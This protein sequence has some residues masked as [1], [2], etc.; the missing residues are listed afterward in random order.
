MDKYMT[1]C[2]NVI[3][4][5][6]VWYATFV[7]IKTNEDIQARCVVNSTWICPRSFLYDFIGF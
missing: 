7:Q 3:A 2:I 4:I 6:M 1:V 5:I